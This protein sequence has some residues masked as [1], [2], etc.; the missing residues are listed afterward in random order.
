MT[1]FT[2]GCDPEVFITKRGKPAS[3]Y[4]LIEGTKD[5]PH[6][7]AL[8]AYQVD[9]MA[10]E[11]NTEPVH[12]ANFARF[13]HVVSEQIKEVRRALPKGYAVRIEP[14][15]DFGHEFISK[16][17]DAA[18]ELGCDP[19]YNAYTL[20]KNPRPNGDTGFRSGAGH[21]HIGWGAD[22]PVDNDEHMEI[23]AGFVKMLDATVGLFMTAI[24]HEPRRRQLY[25]RAGAFRPKPYGV[26]YR[27]PSNVWITNKSYRRCVWELVNL[28][29]REHTW[30]RSTWDVCRLT[31][32]EVVEI[33]NNGDVMRA[34]RA[35]DIMLRWRSAGAWNR[36]KNRICKM[37]QEA[38]DAA[39]I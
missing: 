7:T 35:S 21:L 37:L 9:G 30:G 15:M 34:I 14:V 1:V 3:A 17:P 29:I 27:T 8:G 26:E 33:I 32:D 10:A 6:K 11:F 38:E 16:Q 19:D 4:G 13:D 20:E 25:G 5:N 28:A 2:L 39:D 12:I 18:K 24:D 31:T 23:C 36:S 22:I